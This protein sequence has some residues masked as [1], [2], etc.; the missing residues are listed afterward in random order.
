MMRTLKVLLMLVAV[1][2]FVSPAAADPAVWTATGRYTI[3]DSSDGN[4]VDNVWRVGNASTAGNVGTATYVSGSMS[5]AL[6]TQ[7]TQIGKGFVNTTL[8]T[9]VRGHG[10][11]LMQGGD[12]DIGVPGQ[13][14]QIGFNNGT[15]S[16]TQTGGTL[17]MGVTGKDLYFAGL[18][19][20]GMFP[21]KTHGL[22]EAYIQLE[23]GLMVLKGYVWVG[24]HN[25]YKD[26]DPLGINAND[27]SGANIGRLT[28]TGGTLDNSVA[29]GGNT[30]FIGQRGSDSKV[31]VL[32]ESVAR[33]SNVG[34]GSADRIIWLK[35]DGS[36]QTMDRFSYGVLKIG[37]DADV[38]ADNFTMY[39]NPNAELQIE[40]AS[41]TDFSSIAVSG[42]VIIGAPSIVGQDS[43]DKL[44]IDLLGYDPQ[45][46]DQWV[47]V[48]A[49]TSMV[50]DH[51]SSITSSVPLGPGLAWHA[52]RNYVAKQLLLQVVPEPATLALLGLGGLALIRRRR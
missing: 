43:S 24:A 12:L 20:T 14:T 16:I 27:P 36:S 30:L 13:H 38:T 17:S 10:T 40:I 33:L 4:D 15:A 26:A 3:N 1:A 32:G 25:Y 8:L 37:K 45:L 7:Q 31:E 51:F 19:S 35:T 2:V 34:V 23:D 50:A 21:Q 52:T 29:S 6:G 18:S 9:I 41:L 49:G 39:D 48:T 42:A 11:V 22:S 46:G 28:M 47:I 44:S 5:T